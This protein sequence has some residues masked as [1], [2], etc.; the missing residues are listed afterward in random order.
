VYVWYGIVVR[1][2]SSRRD[3]LFF[4]KKKW[5]PFPPSLPKIRKE[6]HACHVIYSEFSYPSFVKVKLELQIVFILSFLY[7]TSRERQGLNHYSVEYNYS[8]VGDSADI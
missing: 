4:F 8:S 3:S 2:T 6:K 5:N 7:S 1:Q